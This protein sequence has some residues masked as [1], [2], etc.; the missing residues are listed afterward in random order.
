MRGNNLQSGR[1]GLRLA[2]AVSN[3]QNPDP[4]LAAGLALED[5]DAARSP[6]DPERLPKDVRGSRIVYL[7]VFH[8]KIE[9]SITS[10]R[11]LCCGF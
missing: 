10:L 7:L 6:G 9:Y 8:L 3:S 1:V 5:S 4:V 2:G 11:M